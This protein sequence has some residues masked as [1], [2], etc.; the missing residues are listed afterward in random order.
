MKVYSS[1]PYLLNL[2]TAGLIFFIAHS[3]AF[4][5]TYQVN[6]TA[7]NKGNGL[8]RMT[9]A[10][11]NVA[12]TASV[13]STTKID[14][15][16]SF[17]RSFELFFGCNSDPLTGGDGMT[18]TFHNDPRGLNAVGGGFG[19][20]GIGGNAA[21][22]I[23]PA[24]SIEFDTFDAT[25]SGG[26]NEIASDHLAIDLNG[27][28]N[29]GQPFI[30]SDLMNKTVQAIAAA[31]DLESCADN[32]NNFYSVRVKWTYN[33]TT[34]QTLELYEEASSTASMTYTGDLINTIFAGNPSV[35]WGFTGATGTAANEQWIAPKGSIIPWECT[36]ATSCCTPFTVTPNS[37]T[38]ICNTP[39][40]LSV[41][42]S[43]TSY[44]WSDST[45]GTTTQVTAPGTYTLNVQQSQ[46]SNLCP[47]SATFTIAPNGATAVLSGSTTLCNSSQTAPLSIAL[48]GASP[49]TIV[50]AKDGISQPAV[51]SNTATATIQANGSHVY[52]LVSVTDN[53][54]CNGSVSGSA[55][56]SLYPD[57][58]V[59]NDGVFRAPGTAN[60]SVVNNGGNYVWYDTP[61]GTNPVNTGVSFA[62]TPLL[63]GTTTYYVENAAVS[64]SVSKSVSLLNKSE[65]T[66]ND[67][68]DHVASLPKAVC[69]LEFTANTNFILDEITCL[70]NIPAATTNGR[71]TIYITPYTG[72]APYI[73]LE[74]IAKDSMNINVSMPTPRQQNIVMPLN[75]VCT[76]GTTYHISYEASNN[77]Q[78]EMYFQLLPL[79]GPNAYPIDDDPE[80]SITQYDA[81]RPG[82]YPGLFD[83]K[84][85]IPSPAA[86]CVRTPVTAYLCPTATLSGDAVIC[87]DGI[88]TTN[89]SVAL[90]GASPWSLTYA[91]DGMNQTAIS[92]ITTTPYAITSATGAHVYTLVAVSN[93]TSTGCANGT[94][95]IA[96]VTVNPPAPVGRDATFVSPGAALLAVDNTIGSTYHWFTT[97]IGGTSIN[98]GDTYTTPILTDTTT[99]YVDQ[100]IAGQI[101]C[102]R[103]PV[104]AILV[105]PSVSLFI[106]NLMTPNNDGKNDA[107]E[108]LGLPSGSI[109]GIYNR[110]GNSIYHSDNYENKWK[111]EN[112]SSGVYYYDLKLKNGESYKGWIQILQ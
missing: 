82:R 34:S 88:T 3:A 13:W 41:S 83:W 30:G 56:I 99:Y 32:A 18:F 62:P 106:P 29:A 111:A 108:I 103:T 7:V 23:K 39:V 27:D 17:D 105:A 110:W 60:L 61:T 9:T 81:G 69:Y 97:A 71:L 67:L 78:T 19:F 86:S 75:Y 46:G 109:V 92:G 74:T 26:L 49:W 54:G 80:L 96:T 70:V 59:G 95:G 21:E 107:F 65:G 68:N 84:I 47:G 45:S 4:C 72:T 36:A 51:V 33:N 5:Q 11:A 57:I 43:Y 15:T 28:V 31:R 35:Y 1:A 90:T 22:S 89:L 16:Q 10:Q 93:A 101:S 66:G 52:T 94:S 6:G 12:Q 48:T 87:N 85:S 64:P 44:A 24:L 104:T 42:G 100:E 53:S 50:Y 40:T 102:T 76:A 98:T 112:I 55:N 25:S 38:T 63:T 2:L 79:I 8:V 91:I 77:I 73:G 20:L 14:L 58:P 37:P